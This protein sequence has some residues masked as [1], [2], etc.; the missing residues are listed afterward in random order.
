M[1][2]SAPA[3]VVTPRLTLIPATVTLAIAEGE[4]F[5]KFFRM[6][7]VHRL[8][9]QW[10][11]ECNDAD[12]IASLRDRLIEHPEQA[13][14]WAWYWAIDQAAGAE[15]VTSDNIRIART[16]VG[17]GGFTGPPNDAGEV[18]IGYSI[19]PAFRRRGIATEGV[20]ALCD[21]AARHGEAKMAIIDTLPELVGSIGVAKKA[22][23]V[24]PEPGPEEGVIRFRRHLSASP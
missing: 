19:L 23:F 7:E 22:G 16:L 13:G 8:P 24:G 9:D 12:K 2:H 18:E 3:P 14:W 5:G 15:D 6:L 17:N 1:P 21:W 11:P 20:N 10:P 4:D